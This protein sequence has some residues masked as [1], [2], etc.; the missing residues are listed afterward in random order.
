MRHL[1]RGVALAVLAVGCGGGS[2]DDKTTSLAGAP[3]DCAWLDSNN[4]W[5]TTV[6]AATSCLPDP[7][8]HGTL[9]ADGATCTYA[10]GTTVDFTTPVTLPLD[11]ENEPDWHFTVTTDGQQCLSYDSSSNLML[12][13]RGMTVSEKTAGFALQVTCPDGSQ[14]AAQNALDLFGC[15]LMNGPGSV[16]SGSDTSINLGLLNG[17][18]NPLPVFDCEK[19]Q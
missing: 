17:T 6:A 12:D 10:S 13:V 9:S 16:D 1:I 15:L 18:S 14:Y 7:T 19:A 8:T 3:L 11:F 5:K 4:C 2:D